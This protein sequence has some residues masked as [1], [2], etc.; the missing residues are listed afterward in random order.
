[1]LTPAEYRR[2]IR[3]AY[4]RATP[5]DMAQGLAWYGIAADFADELS[6][7]S[8]LGV[9]QTAGV[10]AALSPMT[11]W[12]TNV[13]NARRLTHEHLRGAT[14]PRGGYGF[15]KNRDKAWRILKGEHPLDV[16]GG[17]KVR[18]FYA[19]ILGDPDAV[20]VDRWAIRIAYGD[21]EGKMTVSD[22]EYDVIADAFRAVAAEVELTTHDLQAA[23]WVYFRRVHARALFDPPRL[24]YGMEVD[25]P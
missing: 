14:T 12:S 22:G 24:E 5:A 6:A 9:E 7:I 19:N 16:L 3:K 15:R 20:T 1:M 10:I 13:N 17:K 21:P 23:V 2:N 4:R 18:A 25:H 8:T 11:G